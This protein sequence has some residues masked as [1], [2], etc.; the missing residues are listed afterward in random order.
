M[1][2][3]W[4][5]LF[6]FHLVWLENFWLRKINNSGWFGDNLDICNVCIICFSTSYINITTFRPH[7][8]LYSNS[9]LVKNMKNDENEN[10][11]WKQ[12]FADLFARFLRQSHFAIVKYFPISSPLPHNSLDAGQFENQDKMLKMI[13]D[14]LQ[15]FFFFH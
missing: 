5:I 8:N 13:N 1:K 14:F 3:G 10:W 12:F 9:M 7:H 15:I 4:K 6:F 2:F 11:T